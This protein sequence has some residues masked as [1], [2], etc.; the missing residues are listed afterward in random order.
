M[1]LFCYCG[2]WCF[3]RFTGLTWLGFGFVWVQTCLGFRL[4]WDFGLVLVSDLSGFGV[5]WIL[6]WRVRGRLGVPLAGFGF[7]WPLSVKLC[8][9][10]FGGVGIMQVFVLLGFRLSCMRG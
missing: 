9:R 5:A 10:V 6:G 8:L 3:S 1:R 2:C 7:T 4:G